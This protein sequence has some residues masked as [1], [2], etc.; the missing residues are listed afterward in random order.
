MG[1]PSHLLQEVH[2]HAEVLGGGG[3]S[4]QQDG[5]CEVILLSDSLT[6]LLAF[7][8]VRELCSDGIIYLI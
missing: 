8:Y 7:Q 3:M 4:A 5:G 2:V 6:W 1:L